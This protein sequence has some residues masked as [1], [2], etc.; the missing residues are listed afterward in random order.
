MRTI[1][2]YTFI[3]FTFLLLQSCSNKLFNSKPPLTLT[4]AWATDNTLQTPESVLYDEARDVMYVSNINKM[5]GNSRDGDGF[6]STL[7]P[8]GQVQNLYWVTGLNDPK[9]MTLHNNVLYVS[10]VDE[11]VAISTQSGGVL[12]RYKAE[13][14]KFLNDVIVDNSGTIYVSDSETNAIYQ[15]RNGRV[16]P[17]IEN[18]KNKSP[19]GLHIGADNKMVVAFMGDGKLNRLDTNSKEFSDYSEEL[20]SA[21]GIVQL[22]NGNYLVSNWNGEIY[23]VNEEGKNWKVLDTKGTKVNAADIAYSEETGL[24]YVPTFNDNRVV[25]YNVIF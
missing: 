16:T 9:G 18:T 22:K 5:S 6:I 8:D 4:E 13:N 23:Y 25:A 3:F 24:L 1:A 20:P 21:D 10:D 11:V 15:F 12:G 19:N 7:T 14:A 17:W 2:F